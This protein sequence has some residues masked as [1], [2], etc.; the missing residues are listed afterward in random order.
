MRKLLTIL[1]ITLLAFPGLAFAKRSYVKSY[2][3]KNGTHVSSHY[4]ETKSSG[5]HYK[6]PKAYKVRIPTKKTDCSN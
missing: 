4:R 5:S 3:R 2:T 6:A 1:L